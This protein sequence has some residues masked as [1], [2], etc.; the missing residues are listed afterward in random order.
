MNNSEIT[1]EKS[2]NLCL[3]EVLNISKLYYK[4]VEYLI[5]SQKACNGAFEVWLE[6]LE[7]ENTT[8]VIKYILGKIETYTKWINDYDSVISCEVSSRFGFDCDRDVIMDQ[9]KSINKYTDN[10]FIEHLSNVEYKDDPFII[11]L[12]RIIQLIEHCFPILTSEYVPYRN[13]KIADYMSKC[14]SKYDNN[15]MKNS[16]DNIDKT[17]YLL[18]PLGVWILKLTPEEIFPIKSFIEHCDMSDVEISRCDCIYFYTNADKNIVSFVSSRKNK[19]IYIYDVGIGAY[20]F[21]RDSTIHS[22][23][24]LIMTNSIFKKRGYAFLYDK[25]RINKTYMIS[26]YDDAII[27]INDIYAR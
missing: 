24:E 2:L 6:C 13:K 5:L 22:S 14:M 10:M 21:M 12:L 25:F 7:N 16:E 4:T 11:V 9:L 18:N 17:P 3:D 26:K 1:F 27:R 8:D 15:F 19:K 23:F 20:S